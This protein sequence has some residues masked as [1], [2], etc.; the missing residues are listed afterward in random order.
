MRLPSLACTL[1]L[2]AVL[3]P[4][5]AADLLEIEP[6]QFRDDFKNL[7]ITTHSPGSGSPPIARHER[8]DLSADVASIVAGNN[9]FAVDMYKHLASAAEPGENVL[10]S[11]FSISTALAMTY[12]GARGNTAHQ[13]ADVLRFT[14]PDDRLHAAFGELM[15]DL[16]A[17]REGYDLSVAN[18]LFGQDGYP[19]KQPFLE[20]TGANYGAP[21]ES[22]NFV[23]DSEAARERV[24]DWVA[25]R[26]SDR[27]K[28]LMP[29]GS[30]NEETRLVLANA[31]YFDGSWKYEFDPHHTRKEIFYGPGGSESQVDMM[32]QSET[33]AYSEQPGFQ[34]LEMPYAGDDLSMVVMLPTDRNGLASLEPSLSPEVLQAGLDDLNDTTVNVYLPKFKFDSSF[35]MGRALTDLGMTDAFDPNKSNF[36]GIVDPDVEQLYI[37]TAVHKAF[38]DVNEEGTEAAA[39]TGIGIGTTSCV[40]GPPHPKTFRADHPFLFALRDRHSGSLLFLGRVNEAGEWTANAAFGA[41]VPEPVTIALVAMGLVGFI[42][43]RSRGRFM[44]SPHGS[45]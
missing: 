4:F 39:A 40:C 38:I 24:N 37:Q 8:A 18:R 14:L 36:S 20:T 26:T 7:T 31:I 21:L 6:V 9:R 3:S 45:S 23:A 34:M 29:E 42:M 1:L 22:L 35:K 41:A 27:I 33:L 44:Q 43:R 32:F 16:S 13:M 2:A 30:V 25:E 11:P 28:N 15:R 5:A 12:A 10:V 19:F 17:D